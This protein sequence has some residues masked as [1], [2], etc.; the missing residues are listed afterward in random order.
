MNKTVL[1]IGI[2]FLLICASFTSSSN[3][4]SKSKSLMLSFDGDILYVGGSGPNNYTKIQDAINDALSGDTVYVYNGIYYE[5]ITITKKSLKL[6]GEDKNTTIIDGGGNEQVILLKNT[7]DYTHICGF[8]I[9]NGTEGWSSGWYSGIHSFSNYNQF[10]DNIITNNN[11][12]IYLDYYFIPAYV[13]ESCHNQ[14]YENIITDNSKIG[15]EIQ[16][17]DITLMLSNRKCVH[18]KINK[19]TISHN[20]NCGIE[21]I[22]FGKGYT[23]ISGNHIS[24]HCVN[25]LVSG[26]FNKIENNDVREGSEYGIHIGIGVGMFITKTIGTTVK[27]N[28]FINNA[29]NAYFEDSFLTRWKGNYWDDW[30]GIVFYWILGITY[31]IIGYDEYGWPILK[32]T[33]HINFDSSPAQEP[34]DIT[35]TQGCGIE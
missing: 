33:L 18:N 23:T 32:D 5:N 30:I 21:L 1:V 29:C 31:K 25:I 13:M 35:T 2:I 3:S 11:I 34:Y 26:Y 4:I 24:N 15:I 12:G 20:E 28:N 7:A 16:R 19:N 6:N 27:E 22:L 17:T 14:I 10:Y 9:Q 8:T